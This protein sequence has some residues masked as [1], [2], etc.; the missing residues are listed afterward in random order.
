MSGRTAVV[1]VNPT[2]GGG[3]AERSVPTVIARLRSHG[4]SAHAVVGE[5]QQGSRAA[6]RDAVAGGADIVIACGGDGTVHT[7]LQEVVGTESAFG[8]LP[9]GT[10]NDNARALNIPR[11]SPE[12][13]V[14]AMATA[15]V[16]RVDVGVARD[17]SGAQ[18]YFL[19][20]LSAG[21]DSAVNER[22][23]R[24]RRPQGTARYLLAIV[25]ELGAFTATD[26]QLWVD[27]REV[28]G[29]AMLVAVG[30][31]M[32]YGGGMKVCPDARLD[33][34][35]LDVT[36]VREVPRRTFLTVFPRVFK[37]THTGHPSVRTERGAQVRI[38]G[39]GPIAYADGERL[40]PLPLDITVSAGALRVVAP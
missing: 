4:I 28:S 5:G 6:A 1:V 36:W 24:M 13:A 37:G 27:G 32:S 35:L 23:N 7:V 26:Y 18:R 21:F 22:A 10:G 16:R 3:R 15:V 2:A 25:G 11:G 14:D 12:A 31:G 39:E 20:V 34:G 40:G 30:N 38:V 8:I 17:A 29:P 33:D 19:G 9:L